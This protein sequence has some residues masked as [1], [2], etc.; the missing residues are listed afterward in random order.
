M[1]LCRCTITACLYSIYTGLAQ[2]SS[3]I[4]FFT[5]MCVL[6]NL[7]IRLLHPAFIKK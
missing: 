5:M 6:V 2:Q 7:S 4:A 1:L 3:Q